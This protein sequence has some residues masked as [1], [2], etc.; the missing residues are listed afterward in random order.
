M[1]TTSAT[2]PLLECS[3]ELFALAAPLRSGRGSAELPENLRERVMAGFDTL[4]RM[5]FERSIPSSVTQDAKYALAAFIDEAV[6]ASEWPGRNEWMSSPLQ[7]ELFGEHLAGEGFFRRLGELRQGG[8]ANVDLLELYYVCLQL[9]FEGMYR[10]QGLE[11]LMALQVDLRKQLEDYRGVPDH[12]LSTHATPNQ[13]IFQRVGKYLP[14]WVIT[15]VTAAVLVVGYSGYVAAI[16]SRTSSARERVSETVEA[17]PYD[18]SGNQ[19]GAGSAA[20]DGTE[21]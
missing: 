14:Y 3:A 21:A 19:G 20:D 6:I 18:G 7:L 15:S 13:G 12:R 5:A 16:E 2:N 17:I 1:A 8:E 11:Q 4:E 10:M 9:G